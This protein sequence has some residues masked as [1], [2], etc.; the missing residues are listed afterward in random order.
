MKKLA[1]AL[2]AVVAI[3]SWALLGAPQKS[4]AAA[5]DTLGMALLSATVSGDGTVV[6]GS[7]VAPGS[8]VNTSTGTY[9]LP[10]DRSVATC[11]CTA[12]FGEHSSG[13]V[14]LQ[15]NFIS[16]SCPYN[17]AN[18]VRVSTAINGNLANLP[19]QLIVFCPK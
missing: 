15:Q 9:D 7:G 18:E 3:V 6:L 8:N 17:N 11:T 4:L 14:I 19:F 16:A 10:F 5:D 1:L 13:I 2:L 12:S